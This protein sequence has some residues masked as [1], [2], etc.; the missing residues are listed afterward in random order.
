MHIE[1]NRVLFFAI[2]FR[3]GYSQRYLSEVD[4]S[5][6]VCPD[7][8]S[9]I[10]WLLVRAS[11]KGVRYSRLICSRLMCVGNSNVTCS[12]RQGV[13]SVPGCGRPLHHT[14]V[15]PACMGCFFASVYCC[16]MFWGRHK[17]APIRRLTL[18]SFVRVSGLNTSS[19]KV[20]HLYR[21]A[22]NKRKEFKKVLV[23]LSI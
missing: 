19:A 3:F 14:P 18:I 9:Q 21:H 8:A 10:P 4:L 23:I 20:R 12:S 17:D 15:R 11:A 16:G 6:C 1:Y 13:L 2:Q 5:R 22:C 7:P